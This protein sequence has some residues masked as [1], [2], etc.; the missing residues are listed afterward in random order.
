VDGSRRDAKKE[1]E[2][3]RGSGETA[4]FLFFAS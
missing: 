1:K 3:N 4:C 2:K